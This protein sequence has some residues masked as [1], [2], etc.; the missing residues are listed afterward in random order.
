MN[1][2]LLSLP[3]DQEAR[4]RFRNEWRANFAVSANAGS[5]KTT[6]IS[7]RLAAMALAPEGA[8]I[9]ARTAV[10]TFTRKAAGQI[11]RRARGVLA[12]RLA[13][14]QR[15]DRA[16]LDHLERAFFGTI[17]S[18]C[19]L[20]AR[21]HG[22]ALGLHL[23]PSVVETAEME[24]SLWEE[25]LEQDPMQ[26]AVLATGQIDGFLRHAPLEAVFPLARELDRKTAE[27]L[28]NIRPAAAPPEPSAEALG[29]IRAAVSKGRGAESLR[30]N[31][32]LVERWLRRFQVERSYLPL[33]KPEGTAAEIGRLF[34]EF[35]APLKS[36]LADVGAVMAA[37]LALRYRSWRFDRGVQ[38]YADQVE[39]ALAVLQDPATLDR[40]RAEGWRVVLDEAQDTD[41]QQFSV[42]VEVARPPGA[43]IGTWPD[44]GGPGPRAG[45]FCLVGD[46]QQSIYGSRADVRNFLRHLAAFARRDGGE[47]LKFSVTFRTPKRLVDVLNTT[48]PPAF[49]PGRAHN[50]GIPPAGPAAA[51]CLQ[52][53]YVPLVAAAGSATGAV[54]R[55]VVVPAPA[56]SKVDARLAGEMRQVASWLRQRGPAGV[57]ARCWG[58]ICLLAP[59]NDWLLTARRELERVGLQTALQVRRSRCGDHPVYAWLAGLLATLCDP[60]NS[61]EAVGVFREIFAVSDALLVAELKKGPLR[62]DSPELH[63]APLR[64]AIELLRAFVPRVDAEGEPLERFAADLVAATRLYAKADAIDSSGSHRGELERLLAGAAELG[65]RGAG[66]RE[67]E[68]E[69]L[70]GLDTDRPEGE[71]RPEAIN[72]LTSH[73]AKGLEWPVII[74]FGLW[75]T[76]GRFPEEGLRMVLGESGPR[77]YFDRLSMPDIVRDSRERERQ[78]ELVRLLYVTLTRCRRALI[79]P[80]GE[81]IDDGSFFDLWGQE[82]ESVPPA[83]EIDFEILPPGPAPSP[84]MAGDPP[85]VAP[86]ID[87][88]R[89]LLP[90]Q[91]GGAKDLVRTRLH[92]SA[93]DEPAPNAAADPLEYGMWWHEAL[94]FF[95]WRGAEA[96]IESHLAMRLVDAAS[97]GFG[98][99][100]TREMTCLRASEAWGLLR[101]PHWQ[102]L[103][104]VSVLARFPQEG[105][106]VDGVIDLLARD[107]SGGNIL[108]VDWK[109]NRARV[110]ETPERL[111][112]RLRLEYGPQLEAYRECIAGFFPGERLR[113]AIYSTEF[114]TWQIW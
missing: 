107:G 110:G 46:G 71:E 75:R 84:R 48:L 42:L 11:G 25:F 2:E 78:R 29:A 17:H 38:T 74:P 35:L 14:T 54:G 89:R 68:R 1:D 95:P 106:W 66:P 31:Q 22:Q 12:R 32:A 72:L 37:E 15:R 82:L 52:V 7:E 96:E 98:Q 63:P 69:L 49:G 45:H 6:A 92:D 102:I 21:R 44:G 4:E 83:G 9:L 53:D 30:R 60:A 13:T 114:G 112:A 16:P 85:E 18:F 26:F 43:K 57:G 5:G 55:I 109:T 65:L 47:L 24:E 97:R 90:H 41:P 51:P 111:L 34:V 27:R 86:T 103:T 67:W 73:S 99:R 87:F 3:A 93:E 59:R 104:E 8:E 36:W 70:R 113:V 19:L 81:Q 58:E 62:W 88:P 108:V 56:R 50:C 94:Q 23:N 40:I 61:F 64:D 91:L 28:V 77:V 39:S 33:P 10:V 105:G 80:V 79:L 20:L 76:I 100:A 101:R